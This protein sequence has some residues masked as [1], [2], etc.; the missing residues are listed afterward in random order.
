MRKLSALLIC[1]MLVSGLAVTFVS[2]EAQ[3]YTNHLPIRINSDTGFS[4]GGYSGSGTQANPYIIEDLD[5]D[6]RG[7]DS[8]IYIGNTTAYFTVKNNY[9][10]NSSIANLHLNNVTNG[11]IYRNNIS[12]GVNRGVFFNNSHYNYIMNN[13]VTQDQRGMWLDYSE[14]NTIEGNSVYNCSSHGIILVKENKNNE[15]TGNE[16]FE[17][18]YGLQMGL[19]LDGNSE[20]NIVHHN[21]F[22]NNTYGVY[23]RAGCNHNIFHNN[24]IVN[25]TDGGIFQYQV[26][27]EFYDNT[28]ENN[29][30]GFQ[31]RNSNWNI[32]KRNKIN[33]NVEDG[34]WIWGSNNNTVEGNHI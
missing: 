6:A 25:S 23:M 33:N 15:I 3:G 4:T 19:G 2:Y 7:A 11:M 17:N 34:V 5:I 22:S 26:H 10:H 27:N 16:I 24:T 14:N 31:L 21:E 9:L 12:E 8:C 32:I 18:S 29:L 13:N 20:E 28:I 30:D 1:L